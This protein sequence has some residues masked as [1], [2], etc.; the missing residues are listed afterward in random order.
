MKQLMLG[1]QAVAR[2][3][4]EAGCRVASSYPGTPST[5]IT[6]Q[7]SLYEEVYAE[8]APNEKVAMEV[9][10]GASIGGARS[11]C[12]MKH[13]GLNV[14]ADPLFTAAYTGVNA[15]MVICVADDQGMHSSQNEQDSRHYAVSAKV[16]MVEPAD[17]Q[18]CIDFVKAAYEI[19][20]QFDTPVILRTCTRVAHSQSIVETGERTE[21][22]L[23]LYT[24][25][26]KKYVMMPA[27]AVGRHVFVEERMQ[28]LA[29]F[30]ET[31]GLN[32]VEMGDPK[33]GIVTAGI[34]Y[35]YVKE[36][37][38]QASVL[39]LGMVHPM[40]VRM[41]Q[42]FAKQ[43]EMLYVVEELDP[44]IETHCRVNGIRVDGGKNLFGLL[45][46]LSQR[47]VAQALGKECPEPVLFGEKVPVRPPVP[48]PG[49][50]H[51]GLFYV[52][53][54]LKVMVSGDIGCYTLGA[55][56]PLGALDTTIC[57]GASISGLHGFN[58]ARG[59][60]SAQKSVAVIGD[61]T[62]IHSGI[63]GLIDIT[64]NRGHSTVLVLDN[65]ITGMTGHQQNPTTGLTLKN[66]PAPQVSIE[67][68]CGA[69][70][71]KRVRVV[72]PNELAALEAILKEELTAEEPSVIITRRPCALLKQVKHNPPLRVDPE[73]CKSCKMCMK[74][75][76][77]A[78]H[79]AD[80]KAVID[81]T[82]CV[83]CD[84]CQRMCS[85]GAIKTSEEVQ[86]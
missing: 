24:K 86:G 71:V 84:L 29:E 35:Q 18:E 25:D 44:V 43:V 8:W 17:S 63:T 70:G 61:S 47:K 59:G 26:P 31:S 1:N 15:G 68:I 78:I 52:L 9:A 74:I 45:G 11:F 40:P 80:G 76:C 33:I 73:R 34:C 60:D 57:M 19:S 12:A 72:D 37:F 50:P 39:K 83:G 20:E 10:L 64:Y 55:L 69:A 49:C 3:L 4:Y 28:K 75:G 5:E 62:F 54:K 23:R 65:S 27:N 51:R 6:E 67:K 81:D 77:P 66:Q 58:Q 79:M 32:R 48:C 30:A 14:A 36:A 7:V 42:E 13:V 85:F 53:S 82:L 56:P 46:E 38:P 41:I 22:P 16:P 2:G 21:L